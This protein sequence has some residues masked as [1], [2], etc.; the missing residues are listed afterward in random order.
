MEQ[1]ISLCLRGGR[2]IFYLHQPG[3][4]HM[5]DKRGIRTRVLL[6][7]AMALIIGS[8]TFG[9]LL[10]VRHRMRAS[11]TD[12][13]VEDLARSVVTFKNLEVER[14]NAL[15]REN[16][17]LAD[18]PSL[19]ALMTTSDSRTIEDGGIEFWKVSGADLFALAN[20]EGQ[21]VAAYAHGERL[22]KALRAD[23]G[24]VLTKPSIRSRVRRPPRSRLGTK[25]ISPQRKTCPQVHQ[26]LC[27][28][29][30]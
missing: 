4:A 30:F 11:V 3:A 19:K 18:L 15:E 6:V 10:I 26:L 5:H 8:A 14:Q 20:N 12:E 27:N 29:R 25:D 16:A 23:L 2:P 21:V 13:L 17:L 24:T 22:D 28:L 7:A 1:G 9:S